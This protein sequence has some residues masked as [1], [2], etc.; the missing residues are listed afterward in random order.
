GATLQA[1]LE[2][3]TLAR[4][5][6]RLELGW[7]K[8]VTSR[9]AFELRIAGAEFRGTADFAAAGCSVLELGK[10]ELAAGPHDVLLS[11]EGAAARLDFLR[12]VPLDASDGAR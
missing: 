6:Y 10:L 2:V 7:V 9:T 3:A 1:S 8:A 11:V 4:A 5:R 12:L